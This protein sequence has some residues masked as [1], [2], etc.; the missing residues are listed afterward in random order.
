[1]VQAIG[2][3]S[4]GCTHRALPSRGVHSRLPSP[5]RRLCR[6]RT[7]LRGPRLVGILRG[8]EAFTCASRAAGS[9]GPRGP[10]PA[11]RVRARRI[12]SQR[13]ACRRV[14]QIGSGPDGYGFLRVS[15]TRADC[16]ST[17]GG[18]GAVVLGMTGGVVAADPPVTGAQLRQEHY[19]TSEPYHW[20]FRGGDVVAGG[21]YLAGALMV[22]C[23][24]A[25]GCYA[26]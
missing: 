8:C 14:V 1:M 11:D 17:P 4:A 18:G 6:R 13:P 15:G 22:P 21:L 26:L 12:V 5:V 3:A 9:R 2:A 16:G 10:W 20:L 7:P 23:G 25:A 19:V 24:P